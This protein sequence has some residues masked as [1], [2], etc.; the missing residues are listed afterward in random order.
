M[1]ACSRPITTVVTPASS[2]DLTDLATVQ[3]ELAMTGT[4]AAR[5]AV[6]TRYIREASAAIE[7]FCNR[8]FV[9]ETVSDRFAAPADSPFNVLTYDRSRL[10]LSRW[11]IAS[12]SSVTEDG[13]SL[14]SGT[15]FIVD[16]AVGVLIRTDNSGKETSWKLAMIVAQY[17]A[18][19]SPIPYDVSAAAIRTV[20]QRWFARGRDPMLRGEKIPGVYEAQWWVAAGADSTADG[21]LSPD[22]QA[23]LDNYRVPVVA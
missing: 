9:V 23:L 18:G 15:D 19:Y 8:V 13:A 1:S 14:V 16:S 20:A 4:D 6:L 3:A 12:V 17:S 5:D 22:V 7:N 10:Q 2:H 21:N 11:P